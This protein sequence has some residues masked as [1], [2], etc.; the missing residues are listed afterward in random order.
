MF[1][2]FNKT[3]N[4]WYTYIAEKQFPNF[5]Y[6]ET[7]GYKGLEFV[8]II[9]SSGTSVDNHC[10]QEIPTGIKCKIIN[11]DLRFGGKLIE[12]ICPKCKSV[13]EFDPSQV[14]L[15]EMLEREN[16]KN[17]TTTSIQIVNAANSGVYSKPINMSY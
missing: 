17:R 4:D 14:A 12:V 13:I 11:N 16:K 3:Y 7:I 6:G 1:G 10:N 8:K 2:L 5:K 9:H 15:A